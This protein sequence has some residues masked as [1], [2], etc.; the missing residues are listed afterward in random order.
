MDTEMVTPSAILNVNFDNSVVG[1]LQNNYADQYTYSKAMVI[2]ISLP[3]NTRPNQFRK[4][5]R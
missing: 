5:K 1:K 4:I 3:G 2:I